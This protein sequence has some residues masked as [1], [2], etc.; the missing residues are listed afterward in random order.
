MPSLNLSLDYFD[1]PKTQRL[2]GALGKGVESCPIRLWCYTA[3]FHF[4]DGLLQGYS[5]DSLE[6][7]CGWT[8]AKGELIAKIIEVGFLDEIEGGFK[9]HDWQIHGGHFLAY[10]LKALKMNKLRWKNKSSLKHPTRSSQGTPKDSQG[11]AGQGSSMQ[12]NNNTPLPPLGELSER[13]IFED[14]RKLWPGSKRGEVT[15]WSNFQKKIKDW[16]K[17]I[18][19]LLPAIEKAIKFRKECERVKASFTPSYKNFSTWINQRCWEEE[20]P[21]EVY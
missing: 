11:R 5:K 6:N 9:V 18:P 13:E 7:I 15:E 2:I 1:H 20:F 19:L 10:H 3:K 4:R 21:T 12:G 17:V 16:Q 14:A 8:G